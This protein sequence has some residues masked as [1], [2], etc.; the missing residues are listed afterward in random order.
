MEF[1][2][3]EAAVFAGY[4]WEKFTE[5]QGE[6]QAAVVA[7]FRLHGRIEAVQTED[8]YKKAEHKAKVPRRRH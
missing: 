3:R 2:A 4:P 8:A 1:E 6:E 7:H 5:L